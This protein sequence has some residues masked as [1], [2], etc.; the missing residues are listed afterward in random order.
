MDPNFFNCKHF[1]VD[2]CKK[3]EYNESAAANLTQN[4]LSV[5]DVFPKI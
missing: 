2:K 5:S 4:T 1:G 3:E